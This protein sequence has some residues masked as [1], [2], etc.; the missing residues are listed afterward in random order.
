MK[1]LLLAP[2]WGELYG[3]YRRLT[4]SLNLNP[5][6]NLGYLASSLIAA[7]REVLIRDLEFHPR[8]T[9]ALDK[10][11]SQFNPDV[12][13]LTITSPVFPAVAKIAEYLKGQGATLIAGGPHVSLTGGKFLTDCPHVDYALAGESEITL[14]R[15]LKQ[16]SSGVTPDVEGLIS[17]DTPFGDGNALPPRI[18]DLDAIPDPAYPGIDFRNYTWSVKGKGPTPARTMITSRGCPYN[19]VFCGIH[20]LTGTKVR[21]RSPERVVSEIR[22]AAESSP[23]RHIVFV[24]DVLT[25]SKKHIRAICEKLIVE[26]LFVT[27]EGDTRADTVDQQTLELMALAG[28]TRI[29]FGIES[30]DETVLR[31]LNKK[32]DLRRVVEAFRWAKKAGMDTR[33]TAMIGNPGDTRETMSKTVRF[34]RK[35]PWLDQPYLSIAQPYPGTR[36]REIALTGQSNLRIETDQL[37]AMRRYGSA[38]MHVGDIAPA[39]MIRIQRSALLKLYLTP[40]RIFYNITRS[41]LRDGLSMALNFCRSII[42]ARENPAHKALSTENISAD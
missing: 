5:P 1:V 18:T 27:W 42:S 35:L 14:P 28:C 10:I 11:Y 39:E 34:M 8:T 15:L 40:R 33:G 9:D 12:V 19:C 32:L 22:Q 26:N 24:D 4:R 13:G 23:V 17:Q 16:I 2:P 25:L 6:L 41:G 7:G 36:L 37:G 3:S 31:N 21:Y 30:G 38:V 20:R 29:N